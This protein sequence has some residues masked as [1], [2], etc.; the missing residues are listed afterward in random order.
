MAMRVATFSMNSRMLEASMQTQAKMAEMQLQQASQ[1]VSIDYGGIASSSRTLINMEVSMERSKT[2]QQLAEDVDLRV[3]TMQD[4][5]TSAAGVLTD[6]RTKLLAMRSTD[7]TPDTV[8]TLID[9][10]PVLMDQL[11]GLLNTQHGGRYLFGGSVTTAAP[12]VDLANYTTADP[13]SYYG[14]DDVVAQVQV[15]SDQTISY[16]ITAIDPAFVKAFQALNMIVTSNPATIDDATLSTAIDMAESALNGVT[17]LQ[18]KLGVTSDVLKKAATS[19]SDY[20]FTLK[21]NIG[22]IKHVDLAELAAQLAT[23]DSQLRA[24]YSALAKIQSISLLDYLR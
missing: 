18:S 8:K 15:A 3:N 23:Y 6:F 2:F 1:L 16:G 21:T 7:R 24:S 4:S 22:N 11:A 9:A 13:T 10:A 12:P 19:Q 20:Q 5:V 17:V 14:G